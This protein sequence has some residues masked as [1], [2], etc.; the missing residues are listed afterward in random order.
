MTRAPIV[1]VAIGAVSVALAQTP[2]QQIGDGAPPEL[3]QKRIFVQGL[4][5][6]QSVADRISASQ[7]SEAKQLLELARDNYS[8]AI[9]ALS[10]KD[11]KKAESQLDAALSDIGKARRLVPDTE[12]LVAKQRAD[13]E[14]LLDRVESLEKSYLSYSRRV[15]LQPDAPAGGSGER[16][17]N[18]INLTL[19]SAKSFAKAGRWDKA[20]RETE[21]ANQELKFEMGRVL[22]LMAIE[23]IKSF[24]TP[25][26]EYAHAVER[27]HNLL[28]LIPVVVSELQPSED[29]NTT[30]EDLKDQN[31]AVMDLAG[32]YAKLKDY[33]KAL[34]Y[35]HS[36][37]GYLEVALT[38]AG[39]ILPHETG[40]DPK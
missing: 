29:I 25:S 19:D 34:I 1:V 39:L 31:T 20:L 9:A 35:A 24:D 27:D 2:M 11:F 3:V 30:I 33:S 32:E 21:K 15:K 4:V 26:D 37:I 22:G 17:A 36:G 28:D 18:D 38:S 13:Y 14:M 40:S 12:A 6:D 10:G 23:Y 16:I 7:Q 5:E 8:K